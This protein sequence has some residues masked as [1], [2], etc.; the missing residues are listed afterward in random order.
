MYKRNTKLLCYKC[1]NIAEVEPTFKNNGLVTTLSFN[2]V[3]SDFLLEKEQEKYHASVSEPVLCP[4]LTPARL[5][6]S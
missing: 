5:L 3:M 6:P 4:I 2:L 1:E